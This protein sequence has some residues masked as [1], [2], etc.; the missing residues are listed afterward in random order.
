MNFY[1]LFKTKAHAKDL[2]AKDMLA[3]C[4]YKA[5]RWDP[6]LRGEQLAHYVKRSFFPS[7]K[8]TP[9]YCEL[10]RASARLKSTMRPGNRYFRNE[11]GAYKSEPTPGY[12]LGHDVNE[13]FTAEELEVFNALLAQVAEVVKS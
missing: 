1:E 8:K 12:I 3:L 9:E 4:V 5:M 13:V 7:T 11:E 10:W 6:D 2:E